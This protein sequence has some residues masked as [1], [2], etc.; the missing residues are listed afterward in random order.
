M[1]HRRCLFQIRMLLIKR[2]NLLIRALH[3]P[4]TTIRTHC[5]MV[6]AQQKVVIVGAGFAGI[7]AARTLLEEG[8]NRVSATVLEASIRLGGRAHSAQVCMR[9]LAAHMSQWSIICNQHA[10]P[11]AIIWKA[12]QAILQL[13]PPHWRHSPA[14]PCSF[15]A[16]QAMLNSAAPGCMAWRG[17]L[18]TSWPCSTI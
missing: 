6:Q 4:S 7:T 3:E 12:L 8:G 18:C 2:P 16:P 10:M 11:D 9:L 13:L 14:F 17:T 15:L 5:H 1:P